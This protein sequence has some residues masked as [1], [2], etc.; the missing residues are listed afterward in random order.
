LKAL[1][2]GPGFVAQLILAESA[3]LC[4]I[5]GIVALLLTRPAAAAFHRATVAMFARFEVSGR[6][7]QMQALC[8]LA[9]GLIAALAPMARASRVRIVDGLRHV[10]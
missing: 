6:T 5:G 4:A 7:L 3:L 9:V 10:G 8:A 1:G 2:F